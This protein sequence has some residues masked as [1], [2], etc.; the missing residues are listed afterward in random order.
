MIL[1]KTRADQAALARALEFLD[2]AHAH[3][4]FQRFG[5]THQN[6]GGAGAFAAGF[7]ERPIGE[8]NI[9]GRH[10]IFI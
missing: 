8:F 10:Q 9:N 6:F 1:R 7:I 5:L 3:A 2:F 4:G